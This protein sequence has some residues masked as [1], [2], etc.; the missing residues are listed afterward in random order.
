M[1][2]CIWLVGMNK[3]NEQTPGVV[4]LMKVEPLSVA[5]Q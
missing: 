3:R 1:L 5:G 2:W 4:K